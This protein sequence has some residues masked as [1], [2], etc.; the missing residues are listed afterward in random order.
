MKLPDL[1]DPV[2][3]QGV[4]NRATANR[5]RRRAVVHA[6]HRVTLVC[7][8]RMNPRHP[9]VG[10]AVDDRQARG[11]TLCANWSRQAIRKRSFD[12]IAG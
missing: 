10:V 3:R 4:R 7:D 11:L 6:V 9:V 1:R 5:L 12:Q 8:V 2:D